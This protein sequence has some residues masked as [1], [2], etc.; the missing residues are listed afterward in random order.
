MP[1]EGNVRGTGLRVARGCAVSGALHAVVQLCRISP[2]WVFR[3]HSKAQPSE[4]NYKQ[5]RAEMSQIAGFLGPAVPRSRA[6]RV[7]TFQL[8]QIT[9]RG[10]GGT[11]L[12]GAEGPSPPQ[13]QAKMAS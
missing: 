7:P 11:A 4:A 2:P 6:L 12:P 13:P 10:P 9:K 5:S 1:W 8:P 3:W